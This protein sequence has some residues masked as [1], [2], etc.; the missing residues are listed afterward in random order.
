VE[1]PNRAAQYEKKNDSR[2]FEDGTEE[3]E[4][5]EKIN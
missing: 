1:K 3:G 5:K 4:R 2:I